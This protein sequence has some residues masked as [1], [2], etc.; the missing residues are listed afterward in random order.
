ML[1]VYVE[2]NIC[3]KLKFE[4]LNTLSDFIAI[5][6]DLE[7]DMTLQLNAIAA[8]DPENILHISLF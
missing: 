4:N 6:S 1:S 5:P 3:P 2:P 7:Q 8:S